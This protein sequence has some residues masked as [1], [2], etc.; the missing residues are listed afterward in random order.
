MG[1]EQRLNGAG[2]GPVRAS[3]VLVVED[4]IDDAQ[5]ALDAI[6]ELGGDIEVEVT[7][8]GERALELVEDRDFDCILLDYGLPRMDG[9]AFAKEIRERGKGLPIVVL[10]G[11]GSETVADELFSAGVD[12]YLDKDEDDERVRETIQEALEARSA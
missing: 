5:F 6:E 11:R 3:R 4:E 1:T 8:Y 9:L 2:R 10:T 12:A 7:P